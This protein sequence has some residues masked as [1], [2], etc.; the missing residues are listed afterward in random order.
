MSV[1]RLPELPCPGCARPCSTGKCSYC[2]LH[3]LSL[4]TPDRQGLAALGYFAE[5]Q[6]TRA[7]RIAKGERVL[8]GDAARGAPDF[9]AKYQ[10][11]QGMVLI[12]ELFTAIGYLYE[13]IAKKQG[14]CDALE[15][16]LD[17][18]RATGPDLSSARKIPDTPGPARDDS[19]VV[20]A[21]EDAQNRT[22][23]RLSMLPDSTDVEDATALSSAPVDP[24][25]VY[26]L[27]EAEEGVPA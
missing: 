5:H 11:W 15:L 27:A 1:T 8:G 3:L 14:E 25:S 12:E 18:L 4:M 17:M 2:V 20:P 9:A 22:G 24:G 6:S 19:D 16:E 7:A 26:V 13:E 10:Q 23:A 21:P